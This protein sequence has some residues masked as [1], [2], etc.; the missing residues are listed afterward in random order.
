MS[1]N[2][3]QDSVTFELEYKGKNGSQ[4]KLFGSNFV[5]K[6]KDKCKIIY[7]EK[8]YDLILYFKLDNNYNH[9]G[10]LKIRLIINNN[11]TDISGMFFECNELLSITDLPVDNFNISD[12]NKSF[13]G[14]NC[15]NYNEKSY[16]SYK[17]D[18][19]ETLYNDNLM[20]SSIQKNTNSP[21]YNEINEIN[22]LNYFKKNIFTNVT[23]MSWMF[24][25]CFSLI[26]LPDISKFDT[27]NVINMSGMFNGCFS[28][29]SLPDISKWNIKNVTKMSG[30]FSRCASLISLPDIS[31]WNIKN[32][33]NLSYMFSDCS[34]LISLPDISK[35]DTKN[36]TN[37]ERMFNVC[38]SLISLPDISKWDTKN[39]TYMNYMFSDCS[40]LISLPDISKWDTEGVRNMSYMFSDCSSLISLPDI[41]KWN[42][43][44]V[45]K[46]NRMLHN[47]SSLITNMKCMLNG[48]HNL[49][50][51]HH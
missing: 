9:N 13:D 4:I 12:I 7:N 51:S 22:E 35:W 26:S 39:V 29:I 31:K 32:I 28:L 18:K 1:L 34:S 5:E 46:L 48:C 24:Y 41:S 37:M 16:N 6:N 33:T 42:H 2:N 11:I 17:I 49:L 8:E 14:N 45:T 3:N 15:N 21:V 25:G 27:K 40:S 30:M 38:S 43:K 20:L 50:N 47:C 10:H 23:S 19:N 44:N 36:V